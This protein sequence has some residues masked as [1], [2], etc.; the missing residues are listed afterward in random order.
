MININLNNLNDLEKKINDIL[1]QKTKIEKNIKIEKAAIL[2]NCSTSKI[3]KF[4][5]KLGFSNYKEYMNF[6]YNNQLPVKKFSN[7]LKRIQD[8]IENFDYTLIEKFIDEIKKYEKII[9]FGYGPSYI[10]AQYF[11]YKLRIV[12]NKIVISA[13]DEVSVESLLNSKSILVIFSTTGKFSSFNNLKKCANKKNSNILIIMEE[14]NTS[15]RFDYDKIYFL[16]NSFQDTSLL[17]YEK[18]RSLFFVFIEEV[19]QYIINNK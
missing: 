7:E 18:S 1:V 17:P 15:I 19:I 3:S 10:C 8:F 2:C 12:T 13:Q 14:Y 11:E 16:T 6:L 9:L 5:K 4:V